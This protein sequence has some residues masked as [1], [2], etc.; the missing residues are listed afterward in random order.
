MARYFVDKYSQ[1]SGSRQEIEEYS[2]NR[3]ATSESGPHDYAFSQGSAEVR[4]T[5]V[6]KHGADEVVISGL[7]ELTVLKSTGSEF[8]GLAQVEYT[9]AGRDLRPDPGHGGTRA[10]ALCGHRARLGPHLRRRPPADARALRVDAQP[11]PAADAVRDGRERALRVSRN[12]RDPVLDAQTSTTFSST[13][14]CG[15]S[16]TPTRSGTPLTGYGLI[17]ASIGRDDA[18]PAGVVWEGINGFV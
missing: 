17:E 12:R 9:L 10:V 2:W 14:P 15:A 7:R 13:C 3:I 8:H 16:I 11:V 5:V 18:P 6:T 1:V 4:T